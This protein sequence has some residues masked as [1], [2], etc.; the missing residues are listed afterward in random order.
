MCVYL[1]LNEIILMIYLSNLA[2]VK[3]SSHW[4]TDHLSLLTLQPLRHKETDTLTHPNASPN[5]ICYHSEYT[6]ETDGYSIED[7]TEYP[8]D[9]HNC[10][11][12]TRLFTQ[13]VVIN[14]GWM[15]VWIWLKWVK[16]R[17][18]IEPSWNSEQNMNRI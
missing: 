15:C 6:T 17:T 18:R 14:S 8:G 7:D 16:N 11:E 3:Y 10:S 9:N 13:V 12:N 4:S 1:F 5:S 2:P